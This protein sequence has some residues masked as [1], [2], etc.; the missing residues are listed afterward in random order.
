MSAAYLSHAKVHQG[1]DNNEE[2]ERVPR[3]RKV[4][5]KSEILEVEL[6]VMKASA[7]NASKKSGSL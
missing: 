7:S 1:T 4:V 6:N 2:V 3:I 5:F